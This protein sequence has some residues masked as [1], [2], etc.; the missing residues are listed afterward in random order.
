[1]PTLYIIAGPNGAGKT[2]AAATILPEMLNCK[3]FVNADNIAAGLSPFNPEGAAFEAGRIML[4]RVRYLLS[5]DVDFALETTLAT[6]SY[7]SLLKEAQSKG[8]HVVLAFFWLPSFAMA[9][10]RVKQRVIEGGHSIPSEV[11]KRRYQRGLENL[12]HLFMAVCDQW[13]LIDNSD[14]TPELIAN[15]EK[16]GSIE[17]VNKQIWQQIIHKV[18]SNE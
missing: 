5:L 10:E 14:L 1:M 17:V 11:I 4:Q 18:S 8:Y 3:E 9:I 15:G 13:L 7:V 12:F 16:N 6:K 2:T